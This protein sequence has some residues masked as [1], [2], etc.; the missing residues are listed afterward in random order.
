M[1][2]RPNRCYNDNQAALRRPG[3][4]TVFDMP[5][6]VSCGTN[7]PDGARFCTA[8]GAQAASP[9]GADAPAA[10]APPLEYKVEGGNLQ[11]ARIRLKPGQELYAEAGRMVYKSANVDWQTR[12]SGRSL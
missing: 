10:V 12:M 11:V 6:C 4:L 7:L 9:G 5:Y 2:L 1:H 3:F 8:C